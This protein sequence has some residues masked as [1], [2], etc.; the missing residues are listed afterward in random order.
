RSPVE[1]AVLWMSPAVRGEGLWAGELAVSLLASASPKWVTSVQSALCLV[2]SSTRLN[3][4]SLAPPPP[5]VRAAG[6]G[7]ESQPS[8]S[9]VAHPRGRPGVP[10][11]R[12]VGPRPAPAGDGRGERRGARRR[13]ADGRGAGGR[14]DAGGEAE[15]GP[16][17]QPRIVEAADDGSA[18]PPPRSL[19]TSK[20]DVDELET[21]LTETAAR[22]KSP[23]NRWKVQANAAKFER[24]LDERYGRL[25]PLDLWA[26]D[27]L[28]LSQAR[29]NS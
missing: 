3:T 25:R 29:Q 22:F 21:L 17:G 19:F 15:V 5:A 7:G 12:D 24:L 9:L 8:P 20:E 18:P 11:R 10:G 28:E 1:G 14:G 26:P 2:V 4:T 16:D 27:D 6:S 13:G 23:S